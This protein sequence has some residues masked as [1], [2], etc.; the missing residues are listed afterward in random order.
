MKM[1]REKLLY[2]G[3]GLSYLIIFLDDTKVLVEGKWAYHNYYKVFSFLGKEK[4]N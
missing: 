1:F 3:S 2:K 4:K